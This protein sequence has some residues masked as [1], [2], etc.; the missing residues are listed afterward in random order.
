MQKANDKTN[1]AETK[2][3]ILT[4]FGIMAFALALLLAFSFSTSPFYSTFGND[5][6]EYKLAGSAILDGLVMFRDIFHQKGALFLFVQAIGE[7]FCRIFN[8]ERAGTFLIQY[9][10]LCAI[11]LVIV[12]TEKLFF[13]D[14]TDKKSKTVKTAIFLTTVFFFMSTFHLGNQVEEFALLFELIGLYIAVLYCKS[15]TDSYTFKPIYLLALG[16]CF[17]VAFWY[18]PTTAVS[19]GACAVFIG[20]HMLFHKK[21]ADFFKSVLF[22]VIGIAVVTIPLLAYYYSK[23]ALF[24]LL[25]QCFIFNVKYIESSK[26]ADLSITQRLRNAVLIYGV[27]VAAVA[28]AVLT[29]FNIFSVF[30]LTL[31]AFNLLMFLL[32][33]TICIFYFTPETVVLF[34]M[35]LAL[36]KLE[37][38][39]LKAFCLAALLLFSF[40]FSAYEFLNTYKVFEKSNA[41]YWQQMVSDIDSFKRETEDIFSK[42]DKSNIF[43]V[44]NKE[45]VDNDS[46]YFYY[47]MRNYPFTSKFCINFLT[48][49]NAEKYINSFYDDFE[50]T[51]PKYIVVKNEFKDG[52]EY[53]KQIIEKTKRDYTVIYVSNAYTLYEIK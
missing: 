26:A 20:L 42:E 2:N 46:R 45:F 18:K 9:I 14:S 32:T 35:L 41:D 31:S 25:D 16:A 51:P 36:S 5:S 13:S 22:G 6:L 21:T 39:S 4:I 48:F 23:G 8:N 44:E 11:M 50:N 40:S 7:A 49:E 52:N 43:Y 37:S 30:A 24:E 1:R 19:L 34:A 12:K 27:P 28:L 38:K 3:V 10:N 15:V 17:A 29:K 33:S 47:H 53:N